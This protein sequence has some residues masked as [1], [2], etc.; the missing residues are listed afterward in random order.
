MLEAVQIRDPERVF[1]AYPH[2]LSGGMGQRVMIAMMLIPGP[3]LLIADEP[4]SALDVTVRAAGARHHGRAGARARHGADL[5][6]PRPQ[7][8]RHLLRPRAGHVCR[9]HR[10]GAARRRG[11]TRRA[12]PIRAA[13]STACRRSAAA[14]RRCRC[15]TAT[16]R[17]A[18]EPRRCRAERRRSSRSTTCTS[19]SATARSASTPSRRQLRG[20]ARTSRFGIVGES[21]SGKSTVLRAICG[22]DADHGRAT[23]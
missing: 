13:C 7:P 9:P 12:I 15:S 17:G 4:T 8:G 5:D 2:E 11:W 21:G 3:D 19:S 16:P 10:R 20:R 23:S 14:R 22:L 1:R 18:R 6:Q